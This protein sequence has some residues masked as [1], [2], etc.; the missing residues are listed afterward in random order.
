MVS[1]EDLGKE[2]VSV[3]RAIEDGV[4]IPGKYLINDAFLTSHNGQ[5]RYLANGGFEVSQYEKNLVYF[6]NLLVS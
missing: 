2:S 5:I 3:A 4:H 6:V 1:N